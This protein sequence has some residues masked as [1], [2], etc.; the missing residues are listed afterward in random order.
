[1][2]SREQLPSAVTPQLWVKEGLVVETA[3]GLRWPAGTADACVHSSPDGRWQVL[4]VYFHTTG[5]AWVDYTEAKQGAL[6][7]EHPFYWTNSR[8][9]AW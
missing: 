2:V 4:P 9:M 3:E 1:M 8:R 5:K 6:T 7:P